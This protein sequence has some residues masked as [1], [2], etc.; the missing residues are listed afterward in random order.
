LDAAASPRLGVVERADSTAN[1]PGD[2]V[3]ANIV[4]LPSPVAEP[5][6]LPNQNNY[7]ITEADK[8]GVGSLKQKCRN[9][10][11]AIELL[12]AAEAKGKTVPPNERSKLVRY[13]GW[14]GLPQVF[15]DYNKEWKTE[16]ERLAALLSREELDSV[17]ATTLNAHY[18]SH[19]VIRAMYVA[20]Q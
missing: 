6:P 11:A 7:R 16:R 2:D 8:L 1:F 18:T 10:L 4:I 17:R 3:A 15:D 20:L 5:E 14:G 19:T 12:L 9:N 13:V